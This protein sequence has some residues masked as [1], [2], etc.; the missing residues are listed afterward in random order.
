MV[1]LNVVYIGPLSF[2]LGYASTKRR[3]Y[4]VDYMNDVDIS[5][6]VLC[7]RHNKNVV[8]NNPNKG[9]YKK[10]DFYDISD[11]INNKNLLK[12]YKE[13]SSQLKRWYS[14]AKKNIIIFHTLLNIEDLYFFLYAKKIGYK[15]IFDQVEAINI[16]SSGIKKRV[17]SKINELS[18][19]FGYRFASGL[20]V[21]STSLMKEAQKKYPNKPLCLLPNSHPILNYTPKSSLNTPLRIFYSGTYASK[22]G[23]EFLLKGVIDA[24]S[25]GLNCELLLVGKGL[26][27]NMNFFEA[28]K[29]YPQIKYLGFVTDEKLVELMLSSDVLAMTRNNSKFSNYGFPFKLTEYLSTGNIVLATN[30]SDVS[31][32][33]ENHKNAFIVEP[34]NSEEITRTIKYII[35]H[36]DESINIANNGLKIM[37][38]NFSIKVVGK[39]FVSFLNNLQ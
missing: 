20:F 27:E 18:S 5:S 17:Y 32:Y 19:R 33:L 26:K 11:F 38:D 4:M 2:P 6:H 8:F 39:K 1:E 23:I 13:G 7:T 14:C 3:K 31:L 10:T 21:I 25:Q 34:E 37:E 30:V 28:I 36:P 12:Y 15:V 24:I 29:E 35:E 16:H 22:E 9:F